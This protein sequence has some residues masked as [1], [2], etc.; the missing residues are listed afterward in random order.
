MRE[1]A[2]PDARD[3]RLSQVAARAAVDGVSVAEPHRARVARQSLQPSL[4][5]HPLLEGGCGARE[6][7]QLGAPGHVPGDGALTTLVGRDALLCL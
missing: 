1:A 2:E 6:A 4:G 3:A 7:L 5:V